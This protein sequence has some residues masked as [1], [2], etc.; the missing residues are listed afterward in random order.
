[1]TFSPYF[2]SRH[3]LPADAAMADAPPSFDATPLIST[4]DGFFLRRLPCRQ[5]F[6][7]ANDCS[8]DSDALR[9]A[10]LRRQPP[11]FEPPPYFD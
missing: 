9:H 11:P 2:T 1:M 7:Y 6:F 4:A 3:I 10:D 5:R 8:R